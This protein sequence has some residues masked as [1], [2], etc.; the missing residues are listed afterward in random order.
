MVFFRD[1]T[2]GHDSYPAGRFVEL[3]P[4]GT[5]QYRLTSTA[6]A[7]RSAPTTPAFP[8]QHLGRGNTI[9]TRV[10]AG[11]RYGGAGAPPK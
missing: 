5:G 11:E 1:Q 2:N 7:I 10:E 6:P 4:A 8:V 3:L 9:G